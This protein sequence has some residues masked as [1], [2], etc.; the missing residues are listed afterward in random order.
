MCRR[1]GAINML[2]TKLIRQAINEFNWQK[3]FLNTNDDEKVEIFNGTIL[4]ILGNLFR[5]KL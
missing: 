3:G 1:F 4:N 2:I 5:K